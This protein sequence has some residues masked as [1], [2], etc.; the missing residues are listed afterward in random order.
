MGNK[1]E[2]RNKDDSFKELIINRNDLKDTIE[3]FDPV[4]ELRKKYCY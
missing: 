3:E 1:Y 4:Y 2:V